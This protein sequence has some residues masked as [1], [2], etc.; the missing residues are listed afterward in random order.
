MC[1]LPGYAPETAHDTDTTHDRHAR[2]DTVV[3]MLRLDSSWP[4][5]NVVCARTHAA[6]CETMP[7]VSAVTQCMFRLI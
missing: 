2:A 1:F 4:T 7:V 5:I 6:L 3:D